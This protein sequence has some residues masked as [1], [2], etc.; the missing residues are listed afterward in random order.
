MRF[1]DGQWQSEPETAQFPCVGPNGAAQTQTM[2]QVLMLRPEPQGDL[3]GEMDVTV[4]SNECGQK[5]AVVRIPTAAT[6]SGDTPSGVYVPDPVT[7]GAS[8]ASGPP[9]TTGA[10]TATGSPTSPPTAPSGPGR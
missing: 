7:I 5:S 2:M 8:K 1:T 4:Q 6:R 10:P 9:T 3:V